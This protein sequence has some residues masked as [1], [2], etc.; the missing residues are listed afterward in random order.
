MICSPGI[1]QP[2][3]WSVEGQ[4]A[5]VGDQYRPA[6]GNEMVSTEDVKA[7]YRLI[8]GRP[9]ENGDVLLSHAKQYQSIDELREAFFNSPEFQNIPF[10]R[11]Q[12][13]VRPDGGQ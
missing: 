3:R 12:T 2:L 7:A 13:A 6:S 10:R 5:T 8:L 4:R 1:T 9:P 11:P